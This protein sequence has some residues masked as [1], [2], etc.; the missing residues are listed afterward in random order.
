[1]AASASLTIPVTTATPA[2]AYDL[3]K[4]LDSTPGAE[5][6]EI[7]AAAGTVTF[8]YQ[9]PGNIDATM[10]RLTKS[11]LLH[12]NT[13]KVRVPVKNLSG[14]V[15]NPAQLCAAL[16]ASPAVR[17]AAYDGNTVSATVAGATN[18]MRYVYEE[19]LVAGLTAIDVPTV[20]GK[21]EFVL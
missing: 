4:I 18:A 1:M 13:I 5:N 3:R 20:A 16:D 14:K 7:D 11:G 15:V 2:Q 12:G 6:F 17:D 19:I 8:D 21:Q 10:R 9:F